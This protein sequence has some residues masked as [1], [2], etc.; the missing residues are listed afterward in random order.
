MAQPV[1]M[2]Q[3]G[4][5]MTEGKIVRWFFKEGE[6]V[7]RGE[8]VLEIETDKANMDVEAPADGTLHKI[9]FAAGEIVPVLVPLAVI[10]APGE[11][12]DLSAFKAAPAKAAAAPAGRPVEAGPKATAGR[13]TITMTAAIPE[14]KEEPSAF[15]PAPAAAQKSSSAVPPIRP[16]RLRASPL[17]RRLARVRGIDLRSLRG[18]GPQGRIIRCDV[19]S[20]AAG[21][22]G[23]ILEPAGVALSKT[24]Y[25]PP[26]PRPP[27]RQP[28]EGRRKAIAGALQRSKAQAPHFYL[29]MEIDM[30]AALERRRDLE[31]QGTKVT[32]NDLLVRALAIALGDEPLVNCR[33]FEDHIDY[34]EAVNIGVAVGLDEGLVVPVVLNAR[35]RDLS[36][37][38]E[39]TKRIAEAA[40]QGKLIGS[41]QGTFT[42]SNLGMFG[43]ESFTAVINPP[44]GAILAAGAAAPRLVPFGGGF[45]PRSILKATLSADHRAIDGLLAAKFMG[46]LKA[47]LEDPVRLV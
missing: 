46:R 40:R 10:G 11:A 15:K 30:T 4:Q 19:E 12:V 33:V 47:L 37:L 44:E 38:A 39:E 24:P 42:L 3:A 17:A 27:A 31:T 26:S 8:P 34:P 28:L 32:V 2:P 21:K 43:V 23:E 18:S 29:T 36:G 20:A 9:F 16:G 14:E 5:T 25:P 41:G 13:V 45:F 7:R 35:E 1:L 22:A 6:K